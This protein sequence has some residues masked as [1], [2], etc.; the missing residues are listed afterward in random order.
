MTRHELEATLHGLPAGQAVLVPYD[1]FSELFP[2]GEPDGEARLRALQLAMANDCFIEN[3]TQKQE[4][5][6]VKKQSGLR[7]YE[8]LQQLVWKH[9]MSASHVLI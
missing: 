4:I 8:R 7:T 6:F 3:R 2:P 1:L 5:L 9:E